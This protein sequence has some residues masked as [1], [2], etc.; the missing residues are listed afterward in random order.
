MELL[1]RL[2]IIYIEDVCLQDS[3]PIVVWLM[4]AD[5]DYTLCKT[6]IDILLNIVNS[7]CNC[8]EYFDYREKKEIPPYFSHES[9]QE[10]ENYDALLGI[11]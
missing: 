6:D 4:M 9:L 3:Y 10:Y 1:R 7:L 5:K 2:P 8:K 11:Y